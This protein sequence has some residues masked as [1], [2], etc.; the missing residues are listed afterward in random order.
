MK[1][2]YEDLENMCEIVGNEL[3]T[4]NAKIKKAE[5]K[6]T[7]DDISYIDKLTHTLKSIKGTL[8]MMD[9]NDYSQRGY[10]SRTMPL[11]YGNSYAGRRNARR[12]SMGRY[13]RDGYSR[14]AEDMAMQLRDLME[15]APDEQTRMDIKRIIDRMK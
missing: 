6:L 13:S 2:L 10:T 12:D 9:E 11:Y 7:G 3:S 5:G 14:A 8:A 4:A 15:D 1:S